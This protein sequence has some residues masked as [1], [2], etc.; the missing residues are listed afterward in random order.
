MCKHSQI[1]LRDPRRYFR[2]LFI[3][4]AM[5]NYWSGNIQLG[6]KAG[7]DH[8]TLLYPN[9]RWLLPVPF[10]PLDPLVQM[11]STQK[12]EQDRAWGKSTWLP[13]H[14]HYTINHHRDT[15]IR[16]GGITPTN[17]IVTAKTRVKNFW[18]QLMHTA[19]KVFD[20]LTE[21]YFSH[22]PLLTYMLPFDLKVQRHLRSSFLAYSKRSQGAWLQLWLWSYWSGHPL[23]CNTQIWKH[24]CISQ[25][26]K[27]Q[28]IAVK[29]NMSDLCSAALWTLPVTNTEF[30]HLYTALLLA[31]MY[32]LQMQRS[33]VWDQSYHRWNA[34]CC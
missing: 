16:W 26:T 15:V 8:V 34:V 2:D 30:R 27:Q 28:S 1:T 31:A 22:W 12:V 20:Y 3:S 9:T 14:N 25:L 4:I 19:K 21:L 32:Q 6:R 29:N 24:S 23:Y 17:A 10:S 33:S 18:S 11:S 13:D 5:S 7:W